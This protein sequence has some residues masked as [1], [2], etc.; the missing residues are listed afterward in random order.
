MLLNPTP[1]ISDAFKIKEM[2]NLDDDG[3]TKRKCHIFFPV[4]STFTLLKERNEGRQNKTSMFSNYATL[5][6][7][8][9]RVLN[10]ELL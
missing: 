9:Y 8:N 3:N 10:G 1:T 2:P 6:F 5:G 4:A 7:G